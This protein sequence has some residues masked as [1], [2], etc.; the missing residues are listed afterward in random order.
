MAQS[1]I[2]GNLLA[3]LE[4]FRLPDD[5]HE[6]QSG[7]YTDTGMRPQPPHRRIVL[8]FLLDRLRQLGD[9]RIQSIQ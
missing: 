2:A 8:G 5:Q 6:S 7:Q 1:Q 4:S 3:A 9:R